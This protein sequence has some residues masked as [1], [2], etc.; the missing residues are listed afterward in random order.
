MVPYSFLLVLLPRC[1]L[2]RRDCCRRNPYCLQAALTRSYP[3]IPR[4]ANMVY[5]QKVRFKI[6][7][8]PTSRSACARSEVFGCIALPTRRL[9]HVTARSRPSGQS[10][11]KL[12]E[13]YSICFQWAFDHLNLS[14]SPNSKLAPNPTDNGNPNS[15]HEPFHASAQ[16]LL[17]P[18]SSSFVTSL[19]LGKHSE[20]SVGAQTYELHQS[21]EYLVFGQELRAYE[22]NKVSA[23]K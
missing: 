2:R 23:A 17:G 10:S 6:E 5:I 19:V 8:H 12:V 22:H 7:L 14:P 1:K 13:L 21:Q 16:G 4:E 15:D 9:S 20:C 3:T 11:T 18:K